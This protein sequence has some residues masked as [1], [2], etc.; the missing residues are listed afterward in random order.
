MKNATAPI[1]ELWRFLRKSLYFGKE[2]K[3][4]FSLFVGNDASILRVFPAV[5]F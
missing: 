3:M 1:S 2:C 5:A 4:L